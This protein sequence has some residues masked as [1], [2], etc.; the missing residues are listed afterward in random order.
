M[1]RKMAALAIEGGIMRRIACI[2]AA[3]TLACPATSSATSL[4]AGGGSGL[5]P[6]SVPGFGGDTLLADVAAVRF[7]NGSA[8]GVFHIKH[9]LQ[10]GGVFGESVGVVDCL[11]VEDDVAYVTGR[12]THALTEPFADTVGTGVALTFTDA[13][14]DEFAIWL[15]VLDAN[16]TPIA[17]CEPGRVPIRVTRGNFIVR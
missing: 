5:I 13:R 16:R 12:I 11:R 3:L 2:A 1:A 14:T 17:P 8:T 6:Q 10:A 4:V 15:Q 9:V 7:P